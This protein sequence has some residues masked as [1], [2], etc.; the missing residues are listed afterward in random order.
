[1]DEKILEMAETLSSSIVEEGIRTVRSNI[2]ERPEKFDNRCTEC[3]DPIEAPRI[4]FG[5]ITCLDCAKFL[6]Q[7]ARLRRH[8]FLSDDY[9]N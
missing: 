1:M 9:E 7:T 2:P 5:C 3:G 8:Q 6:E 4:Q